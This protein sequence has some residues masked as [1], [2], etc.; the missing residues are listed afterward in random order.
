VYQAWDTGQFKV[1]P[2]YEFEALDAPLAAGVGSAEVAVLAYAAAHGQAVWADERRTRALAQRLG[3]P[4]VGTGSLLQM[5]VQ[6]GWLADLEPVRQAWRQQ[7]WTLDAG[8]LAG[9]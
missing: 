3:V 9:P 7:G 1:I 5:L 8:V 6:A 4:V 2:A